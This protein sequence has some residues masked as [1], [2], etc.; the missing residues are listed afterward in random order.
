LT[1]GPDRQYRERTF[2]RSRPLRDDPRFAVLLR[3]LNLGPRSWRASSPG[4]P[5]CRTS[6]LH[7]SLG[8]PGLGSRPDPGRSPSRS[9]PAVWARS[10]GR[11]TCGSGARSRSRCCRR[12]CHPTQNGWDVSRR[13][14][15]PRSLAVVLGWFDD[16]RRRVAAGKK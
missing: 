3:K 14:S 5:S 12:R 6:T 4:N 13:E 15:A 11:A 10:T 7:V 2:F 8:G 16:L 9:A 1:D